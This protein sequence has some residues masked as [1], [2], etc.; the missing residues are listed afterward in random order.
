MAIGK[1]E[2][3][4]LPIIYIHAGLG[5]QLFQLAAANALCEGKKYLIDMS[6]FNNAE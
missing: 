6:S 2:N 3:V 4:N 5:N 1:T